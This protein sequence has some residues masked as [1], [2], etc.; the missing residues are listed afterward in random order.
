[1]TAI[2]LLLLRIVVEVLEVAEAV[3][4]LLEEIAS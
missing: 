3:A 1:M 2:M 4:K